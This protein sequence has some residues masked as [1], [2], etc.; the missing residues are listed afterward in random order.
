MDR[1]PAGARADRPGVQPSSETNDSADYP[2]GRL[3]ASDRG[4]RFR[5]Q[6]TDP[7]R[8]ELWVGDECYGSYASARM[9]ASD[10]YAH[11][12]GF[13]DSDMATHLHGPEDL[14]KWQGR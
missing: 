3:H 1:A 5:P 4:K 9:A 6:R 8:V 14:L 2:A 11:V 12:T 7:N 13:S 10:V